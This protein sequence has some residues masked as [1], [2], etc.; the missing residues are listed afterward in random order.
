MDRNAVIIVTG[1]AGFIG[2]CLVGYLNRKG[3]QNIVIVDAFGGDAK[4]ANYEDKKICARVERD[5]LFD[6]LERYQ[7]RIDFVF[8]LGARTDTTE[9]DYRIHQLLNVDYS[10]KVWEYCTRKRI[11]LVYASSAATYGD[12]ELGYRD[13]HE[14]AER[15]KPLNP[16]G[17]SK[18]EFDKW[19]LLQADQPPFWAGLKFFNV[20]GPNEYHKGRMAS[21]IFHAYQQILQTGKVRL[22]RSH[23]PDFQD[24]EQLRDFI[25]VKDVVDICFWLMQHQP[26]SGLYNVGT[27]KARSFNDLVRALFAS[28]HQE[29]VIEYI[30]TPLDIRDKYQYFTQADM[31][32]LRAAGY[33]QDF[34]SLEEGVRTYV[35]HFLV[36]RKYY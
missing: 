17:V 28:L 22:F 3:Y 35:Q 11:P 9:F 12:G 6:W 5:E 10:K 4:R 19:A 23:R 36:D 15:L 25:Y 2:S 20:Y 1:A 34:Y 18:N 29:P 14:L 21:V 31:N 13:D 26:A 8:H 30:D 32:K 27:G 16:Y 7:L 33:H 24:G